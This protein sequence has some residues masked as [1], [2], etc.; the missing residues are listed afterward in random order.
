MWDVVLDALKDT[1]KV[2]PFLLLSYL[3]IEIIEGSTR[4]HFSNNKLLRGKFAPLVGAGVGIVPQCGFSVLATDLYSKKY[5]KVGTLLAVYIATSDEAIPM[6][7]S[8]FDAIGKL[9][10]LLIC[11]LVLALVVGYFCELFIKEKLND[12]P[13]ET[14]ETEEEIDGCCKHH[15]GAKSKVKTYVWHPLKHCLKI[16][17]YILIVNLIMGFAVYYAGE[18][19]LM[20][21]L[22]SS[23]LA[24]PFIAGLIGLIPNCASSVIITQ[25]YIMDGLSLG[26]AVAGLSVNAGIAVAVL[27]KLNKNLKANLLLVGSLYLIGSLAGMLITLI[28]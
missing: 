15:I 11:K 28:L 13:A 8:N 6:L 23:S 24:Q 17:A 7:V 14:E 5:I 18:E 27:F 22:M 10:P 20:T 19:R 16:S 12:K 2:M 4:L 25:L 26:S 1:L 21:F 3:I 9:W